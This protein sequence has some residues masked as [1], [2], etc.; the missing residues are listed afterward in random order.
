MNFENT[1]K[2]IKVYLRHFLISR[3]I[4]NI[5]K[6]YEVVWLATTLGILQILEVVIGIFLN[7]ETL[8]NCPKFADKKSGNIRFFY[9]FK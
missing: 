2:K 3:I 4:R 6:I 7:S 5:R 1:R 9:F 8:E